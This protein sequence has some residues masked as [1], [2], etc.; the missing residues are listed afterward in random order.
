MIP[1]PMFHKSLNPA[2]CLPFSVLPRSA[3]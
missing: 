1:I 3:W 2:F